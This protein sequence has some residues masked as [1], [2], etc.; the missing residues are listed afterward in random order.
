M[1]GVSCIS[2]LFW[3]RGV[4]FRLLLDQAFV[5]VG[6]DLD[7]DDTLSRTVLKRRNAQGD[8][9]TAKTGLQMAGQFVTTEKAKNQRQNNCPLKEP[10]K[11]TFWETITQPPNNFLA[12]LYTVDVSPFSY[13]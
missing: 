8:I 12:R 7:A 5:E 9:R 3:K 10:P 4:F 1:V 11:T 13:P 6:E 2:N